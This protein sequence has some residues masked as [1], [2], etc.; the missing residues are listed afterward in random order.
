MLVCDEA[1]WHSTYFV[2]KIVHIFVMHFFFSN[3]TR[4]TKKLCKFTFSDQINTQHNFSQIKNINLNIFLAVKTCYGARLVR[5]FSPVDFESRQTKYPCGTNDFH[6]MEKANWRR[7]KIFSFF[8]ET[9]GPQDEHVVDRILDRWSWIIYSGTA[10]Q[11]KR[12]RH[13]F[14]LSKPALVKLVAL[15][16]E[17][18]PF[19]GEPD[20]TRRSGAPIELLVMGSLAI[21]GR[22]VTFE[23]L[24][25]VTFIFISPK[26]LVKNK[27]YTEFLEDFY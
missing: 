5:F 23:I 16:R 26:S 24:E 15:V 20:C 6:P 13:R 2:P 7:G 8:K 17:W 19:V 14:R 25:D 22:V 11:L 10:Y 4:R 18:L 12:F 1:D 21:L 3:V 9:K 27:I